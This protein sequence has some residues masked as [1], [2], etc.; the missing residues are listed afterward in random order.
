M[1]PHKVAASRVLLFDRLIDEDPAQSKEPYPFRLYSKE[2]LIESIARELSRLLN[3]RCPLPKEHR[4][5]DRTV[6]DYGLRDFSSLFAAS[7]TDRDMLAREIEDAIEVFEPRLHEVSIIW[8]DPS[9][10]KQQQLAAN[11]QAKMQLGNLMEP[12]SF[13]VLLHASTGEA[14]ILPPIT[15]ES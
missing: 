12:V 11:I 14:E 15:A 8:S 9:N 2:Q 1:Q 13:P 4:D 3:T 10:G 7:P 6:L 5:M